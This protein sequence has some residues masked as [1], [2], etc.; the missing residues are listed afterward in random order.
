MCVRML[1]ATAALSMVFGVAPVRAQGKQAS[2]ERTGAVAELP[3]EFKQFDFWLGKW[4]IVQE[5]APGVSTDTI[6]RIG[7]GVG[8]TEKYRDPSGGI[9]ASVTMFNIETGTW[10]QTWSQGG[11]PVLQVTGGLEG[12]RMVLKRTVTEG[13]VT[14]IERLVFENI[15]ARTLDQI[16]ETSTDGGQTWQR[17]YTTHWT[18]QR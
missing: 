1:A 10:T 5:G 13:G 12:D 2:G 7:D 9:G 14:R 8:L 18:K 15:K 3:A 6:K 16:F 4:S 11:G 17:G